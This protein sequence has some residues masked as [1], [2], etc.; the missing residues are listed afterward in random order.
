[1]N[2][3]LLAPPISFEMLTMKQREMCVRCAD[4]AY[5]LGLDLH[6]RYMR[7]T[8]L[9]INPAITCADFGVVALRR[10]FDLEAMYKADNLIFISEF[11]T[12]QLHINRPCNF[13]PA[14]VPLR[15][16]QTGAKLT[17]H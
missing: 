6:R 8:I 1:M 11:A 3:D 10:G 4:R 12:I 16:A 2:L 14:D 15:F 5:T 9:E 17:T 7:N 13:F